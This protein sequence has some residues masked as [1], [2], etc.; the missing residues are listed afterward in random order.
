MLA[1]SRL[2]WLLSL[3]TLSLLGLVGGATPAPA[4][5]SGN[6]PLSNPLGGDAE[7]PAL[8]VAPNGAGLGAWRD[9]Q[10]NSVRYS[11]HAAGAAFPANSSLTIEAPGS[12]AAE[13]RPAVALNSS[14]AAVIAWAAGPLGAEEVKASYRPAGQSFSAPVTISAAGENANAPDV[15]IDAGGK[16][17]LVWSVGDG[18]ADP[19]FAEA[20]VH[21]PSGDFSDGEVI[22][23]GDDSGYMLPMQPRVAM[24]GSGNAIAVFPSQRPG[25]EGMLIPVQRA[26]MAVGDTEFGAPVDLPA[27]HAPDIA[28]GGDRATAVWQRDGVIYA[29]EQTTVGNTVFGSEKQVSAGADGA[30]STAAVAVDGA[31]TATVLYQ[32][33]TG[34]T[35]VFA[36]TRPSGGSF[37]QPDQVSSAGDSGDATVAVAPGGAAVA[38]WTRFNGSKE[39]VEA[40]WHSAGA[41]FGSPTTLSVGGSGPIAANLAAAGI[42]AAG[43]STVLWQRAEFFGVVFATTY[44]TGVTPPDDGGGDGGDGGGGGNGGGGDGGGGGGGDTGGAQTPTAAPVTAAP[45]S[46]PAQKPLKCRKGFKKKKV[47]GKPKCVKKP[48][49]AKKH[50]R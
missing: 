30:A 8:A 47:G 3:C 20:S 39:T 38:A 41:G 10:E 12:S 18:P 27:G 50:K 22:N 29:A 2:R 49:K 34:D 32:A 17:V 37:D 46:K 14:G 45:A 11:E 6:V 7:F 24:D 44:S 15:A 35:A 25:G 13:G 16:A 40:S 48:A 23:R 42:D 31:A 36:A 5:W 26:Y 43:N 28:F 9:L 4:A 19:R 1:R 21:G 33:G